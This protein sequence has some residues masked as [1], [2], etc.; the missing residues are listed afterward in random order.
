MARRQSGGH[1]AAEPVAETARCAAAAVGSDR[2]EEVNLYDP[3]DPDQDQVFRYLE[4]YKLRL[5]DH[6]ADQDLDR[7]QIEE[8]MRGLGY[9]R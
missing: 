8:S 4:S 2:S 9:I 5:V 1:G 7:E 3:A 6:Y